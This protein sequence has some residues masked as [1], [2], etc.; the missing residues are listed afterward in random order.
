[1][2]IF[3]T[4]EAITRYYF[5]KKYQQEQEQTLKELKALTQFDKKKK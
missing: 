1:M 2:R 5:P 3:K 4:P